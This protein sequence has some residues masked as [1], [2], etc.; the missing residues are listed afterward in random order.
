[1]NY[2][3]HFKQRQIDCVLFFCT[4]DRFKIIQYAPENDIQTLK[5]IKI[6]FLTDDKH[7]IHKHRVWFV[8]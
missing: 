1:M 6:Y 7:S 8:I 5:H 2:E 4:H 3:F